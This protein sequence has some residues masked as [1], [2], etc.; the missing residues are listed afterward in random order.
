MKVLFPDPVKPMTAMIIGA[1]M[2]SPGGSTML[3][4]V[5]VIVL[6]VDLMEIIHH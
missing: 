5:I 3:G 4:S 2:T 6:Q 1:W